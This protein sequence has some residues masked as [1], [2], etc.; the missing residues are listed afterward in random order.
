MVHFSYTQVWGVRV[1]QAAN[2]N[3]SES[4]N[5][6]NTFT[7]YQLLTIQYGF[8]HRIEHMKVYSLKVEQTTRK[9]LKG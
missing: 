5:T 7:Y 6:Q 1:I 8:V 4:L 2:D 9:I 3:G